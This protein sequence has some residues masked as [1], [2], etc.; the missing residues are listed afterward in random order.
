MVRVYTILLRRDTMELDYFKDHLFDLL[1]ESD[2]LDVKDIEDDTVENRFI[3]TLND[4]SVFCVQYSK[5]S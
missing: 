4:G 5:I 3:V 1:N 2:L